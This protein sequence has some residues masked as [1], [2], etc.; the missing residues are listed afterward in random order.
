MRAF[1]AI[2]VFM[3]GLIIYANPPTVSPQDHPRQES[4]V[5]TVAND[6]TSIAYED[7]LGADKVHQNHQQNEILGTWSA[8]V[9]RYGSEQHPYG[10]STRPIQ[11]GQGYGYDWASINRGRNGLWR[12]S[13][14]ASAKPNAS[15]YP[16]ALY[17]RNANQ[18]AGNRYQR[19]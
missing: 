17:Y 13:A 18:Y 8:G 12:Y 9:Y 16:D 10:I 14:I 11:N 6:L 1:F 19:E 7:V 4:T 15:E 2:L 3:I 5:L